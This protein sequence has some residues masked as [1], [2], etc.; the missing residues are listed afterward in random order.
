MFEASSQP[1]ENQLHNFQIAKLQISFQFLVGQ[2]FGI[3][4]NYPRK[5]TPRKCAFFPNRLA[6]SFHQAL[7]QFTSES[8]TNFI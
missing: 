2:P 1:L 5:N 3:F 8:R 6:A 7:L 4:A